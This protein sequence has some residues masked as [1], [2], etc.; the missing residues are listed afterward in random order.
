VSV[1]GKEPKL[2]VGGVPRVDLLP[3]E[4]HQ[5]RQDARLHRLLLVVL[6]AAV[7]LSGAGVLGAKLVADGSAARLSA[8][9]T[10]TAALLAEQRRFAS[11]S[12]AKSRLA[13]TGA[14]RTTVAGHVIDWRGS[15]RAV[16]ATLPAG[17]HIIAATVEAVGSSTTTG[18]AGSGV[19][20]PAGTVATL[21]L[22]VRTPHWSAVQDWLTAL[23]A[24]R[25]FLDASP[26]TVGADAQTGVTATVVVHVGQAAYGAPASAT[27]GSTAVPAVAGASPTATA[28]PSPTATAPA[29]APGATSTATPRATTTPKP[30]STA[31]ARPRTTG[32]ATPKPTTSTAAPLAA[33]V[34]G[35][36]G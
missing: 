21:T 18:G 26:S 17:V 16:S 35:A 31:P 19:L 4:V 33:G 14:A 27:A 7:V 1:A 28:T 20:A 22:Q 25:G 24:L 23:P 12:T 6:V 9:Q 8:A 29:A 34:T 2:V 15:L 30:A 5:R 32:H 13:A 3:P 11:V 10:R 36:D